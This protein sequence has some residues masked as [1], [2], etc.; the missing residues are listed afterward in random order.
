ML[1]VIPFDDGTYGIREQ[2]T[3][4]ILARDGV[5]IS[6]PTVKA[7]EKAARKMAKNFNRAIRKERQKNAKEMS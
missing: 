3:G 5:V 4:K 2:A 7:A 6:R 1:E